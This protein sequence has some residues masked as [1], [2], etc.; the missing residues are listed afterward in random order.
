MKNQGKY[1][2]QSNF[3]NVP[4]RS[5]LDKYVGHPLERLRDLT[6]GQCES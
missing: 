4:D 1:A 5:V 3:D 6:C 2:K